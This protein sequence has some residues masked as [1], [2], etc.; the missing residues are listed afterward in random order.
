MRDD[1]EKHKT[2][3]PIKP[4]PRSKPRYRVARAIA[5]GLGSGASPVAP[6]TAGSAAALVPALILIALG[7][8][9]A[10]AAGIALIAPLGWW[11]AREYEAA[12][13]RHDAP[14]VVVD[15]FLG[16]WI[17]LLPIAAAPGALGFAAGFA[18]FRLFDITKIWPVCWAERALPGAWGVMAD[19][20]VA[21]LY[22][23]LG[24]WGLH[25]VGWI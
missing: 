18:L 19:D 22:A 6:G 10:L 3:G 15:E 11:A 9:W 14:E 4:K 17:A 25:H 16:Q 13:G 7:G 2:P 20:V 24:V 23:A 5:L 12:T 21:G 1:G 8:P